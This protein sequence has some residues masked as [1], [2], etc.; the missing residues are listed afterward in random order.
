VVIVN[1]AQ[2]YRDGLPEKLIQYF[3]QQLEHCVTREYQEGVECALEW[4]QLSEMHCPP[5]KRVAALLSRVLNGQGGTA[6]FELQQYIKAWVED[7]ESE[8]SRQADNNVR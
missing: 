5:E 4:K 7:A 1:Q 8:I 2:S 3:Q 6:W